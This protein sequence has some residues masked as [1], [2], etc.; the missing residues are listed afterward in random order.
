MRYSTERYDVIEEAAIMIDTPLDDWQKEAVYDLL[1]LNFKKLDS[2]EELKS[3]QGYD[4]MFIG[5]DNALY[6][7]LPL[8]AYQRIMRVYRVACK[9]HGVTS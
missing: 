2:S 7:V 3:R 1:D 6:T 5:Y 4:C 9:L 8:G